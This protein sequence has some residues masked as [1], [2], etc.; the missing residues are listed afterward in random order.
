M[1]RTLA[2]I[3]IAFVTFT[4]LFLA[5]GLAPMVLAD[6]PFYPML[7]QAWSVLVTLAL[8][9]VSI[10]LIYA[11]LMAPSSTIAR[12]TRLSPLPP[13]AKVALQRTSFLLAG[14]LLFAFSIVR[15]LRT[16]R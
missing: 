5:V 3:A 14:L 7:E 4:C 13:T 15:V 1:K 10:L 16:F 2:L 11:A 9:S 8:F 6:Q 12:F